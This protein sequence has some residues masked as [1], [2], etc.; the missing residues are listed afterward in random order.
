MPKEYKTKIKQGAKKPKISKPELVRHV[1][2][3]YFDLD[4]YL[5]WKEKGS[6][7]MDGF[8]DLMKV[9]IYWLFFVP[10]I[11]LI[12]AQT[13]NIIAESQIQ[14]YKEELQQKEVEIQ[15]LK[16]QITQLNRQL[17]EYQEKYAELKNETIT[18]EDIMLLKQYINS[19]QTQVNLLNQKLEIVNNH[20]ITAYNTYFYISKFLIVLNVVLAAYVALDLINLALFNTSINMRIIN[21]LRIVFRRN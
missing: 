11:L 14:P 7:T 12:V 18:K 4:F 10:V 20:F 9:L 15:T 17:K 6:W 1:I 16:Q 13:S 19:T 3:E 8:E 5:I 2:G 21:R